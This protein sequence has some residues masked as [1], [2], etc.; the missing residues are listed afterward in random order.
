M[1]IKEKKNEF[2]KK[3]ERT[4]KKKRM[5]ESEWYISQN[6]ERKRG[7]EHALCRRRLVSGNQIKDDWLNDAKR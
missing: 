5:G 4:E 6:A 1:P 7:R 3:K 2:D